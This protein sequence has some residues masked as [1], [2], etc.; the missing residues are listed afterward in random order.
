[1][2]VIVLS[3]VPYVSS[4][5]V[6]LTSVNV[7]PV[8]CDGITDE[9]GMLISQVMRDS[10]A[11]KSGLQPGDVILG[12]GRYPVRSLKEFSTLMHY[13]PQNGDVRILISRG[14]QRG[15]TTLQL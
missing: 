1:M 13:L 3:G 9:D 15:W 11:S 8:L 4:A 12:L 10:V 5:A 6:D 14:G 2:C 7:A